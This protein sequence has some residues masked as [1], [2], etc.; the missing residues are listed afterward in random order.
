MRGVADANRPRVLVAR[1]PVDLPFR[2]APLAADAVHDLHLLGAPGRR[3]QE[4]VSPRLR[5]AVIAGVHESEERERRIAQPAIAIIPVPRSAELLRKRGGGRGDE[6]SGRSMGQRLQGDQRARHRFRP[7][8]RLLARP[9]QSP[10]ASLRPAGPEG[11]RLGE[12]PQGIDR[13]GRRFVRGPVDE[14][15]GDRLAGAHGEF[16]DGGHSFAARLHGRV[17]RGHIGA[18]DRA[19]RRRGAVS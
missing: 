16:G 18:G 1:K 2:E 6:S 12:R 3:A 17:E 15:E 8:S 19:K 13:F 9:G 4:P 10:A 14:R 11:F 7:R 5:L